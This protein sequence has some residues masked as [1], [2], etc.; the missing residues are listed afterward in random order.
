MWG[1]PQS[2]QGLEPTNVHIGKRKAV[3][4]AV[5]LAIALIACVAGWLA[6]S[7]TWDGGR[8]VLGFIGRRLET[9]VTGQRLE[10][11]LLVAAALA[12]EIMLMGW[13]N[14]SVFR[15]LFARRKSAN[16]DAIVFGIL[17]VGL[18]DAVTIILTFG[19]SVETGRAVS[20]I[21]SQ[22][23]WPRIALP[24]EGALPLAAGVAIYWLLTTF[25]AYW[26]HRLMHTP[27]F[28]PLHRFHH[29]AT[30]LNMITGFRQHSV[31][32]VVLNLLSVVSPLLFFK[33]SDSILFIY[34]LVGTTAD[35]LAH[36]HLPWTY[37]W[38]GSWVIHSPRVHQ[39]H[40]SAEDEHRDLHFGICPLWDHLFGTW[41]KGTKAP[42][43]YGVPDNQYE[44]RPLRQFA[45]D[46]LEFYAAIGRNVRS[47]FR[48]RRNPPDQPV[49]N[50][51]GIS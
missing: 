50:G 5:M 30:E 27:Q 32:P 26:A 48:R 10:I 6:P 17:M 29:A 19:I 22:Y 25:F 1:A 12:L 13:R 35:L 34:L 18:T 43:V 31:E 36:S 37:G 49:R 40:H 46:A 20:W 28:W 33:A 11:G 45:V 15:L 2:R 47:C 16:I 41:Y 14:S 23:G 44:D 24:S 21:L 42:S 39:V 7:Y 9:A 51:G 4:I 3:A 38:I 8:A